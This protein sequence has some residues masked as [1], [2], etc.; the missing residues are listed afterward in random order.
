MMYDLSPASSR[1]DGVIRDFHVE[2]NWNEPMKIYSSYLSLPLF[3]LLLQ[4][5]VYETRSKMGVQTP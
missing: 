4:S 5:P 1:G 3:S 2:I